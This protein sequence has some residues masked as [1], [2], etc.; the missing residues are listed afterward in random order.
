MVKYK[1]NIYGIRHRGMGQHD[2]SYELLA[3]A[4]SKAGTHV[5]ILDPKGDSSAIKNREE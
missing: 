3:A 5:V 2:F 4:L 1:E